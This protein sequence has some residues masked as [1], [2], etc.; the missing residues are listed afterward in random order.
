MA[1]VTV[2]PGIFTTPGLP[3]LG[4]KGFQDTFNRPDADTLG[5]T[6]GFPRRPWEVWGNGTPVHGIVGGEGYAHPEASGR[7]I[8][9]VD[10]E[11]SDGVLEVTMGVTAPLAVAGVVFRA[12]ADNRNFLFTY[13]QNSA[14]YRLQL[15]NSGDVQR[16]D[17]GFDVVPAEGDRVRIV[18]DGP[19]ITIF[20]ND[21]QAGQFTNSTH[22]DATRHGFCN[23]T[24]GSTIRDVEFTAA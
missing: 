8:A 4:I 1:L 7:V 5:S 12:A 3:T 22:L 14:E 6:E 17:T 16:L 9:V 10:S 24:Q 2:I 21:L 15:F 23:D 19:S 20:V 11:A 18:L 13:S